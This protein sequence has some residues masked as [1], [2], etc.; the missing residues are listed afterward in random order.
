VLPNLSQNF[1]LHCSILS[2]HLFSLSLQPL[3]QDLT[4]QS[5][6]MPVSQQKDLPQQSPLSQQKD[7]PQ[8][9]L[10][11]CC[12]HACCGATATGAGAGATATGAGA[13]ATCCL[14]HLLPLSQQDD[15]PQQSPLSQ[16]FR[17]EH[18]F[19][20]ILSRQLQHFS[21]FSF[22]QHLPPQSFE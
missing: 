11:D 12:G 7:L 9:S 14:S 2:Q 16:H 5:P 15:F 17:Q 4:Q 21:H 8:Q 19:A 18:S 3:K 6:F 1:S 20:L 22:K 10:F 13:A